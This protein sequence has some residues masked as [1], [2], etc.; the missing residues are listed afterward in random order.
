MVFSMLAPGGL[1]TGVNSLGQ[2]H[3]CQVLCVSLCVVWC[4]AWL[5]QCVNYTLCIM[6]YVLHP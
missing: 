3:A 1:N 2:R 4:V 6:L 5:A